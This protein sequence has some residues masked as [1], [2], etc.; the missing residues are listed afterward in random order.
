MTSGVR[1]AR[2]AVLLAAGIACGCGQSRYDV[3]GRVAYED[4]Q[5][6]AGGGLVVLEGTVD[7]KAVM[8]RGK[9][10][11]DGR[12]AVSAGKAGQGVL[13]GSYRVR[14]IPPRT[15]DVDSPTTKLPYDEKFL[16]CET[17]GVTFEVGRGGDDLVI[18]L[19]PR[20]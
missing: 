1:A 15:V 5:P 9:L 19:G 12:F 7:G 20:P 18:T 4:G 16:A 6:Y 3:A 10:E 8:A 11:P 13:A 17:S 2:V 14:L